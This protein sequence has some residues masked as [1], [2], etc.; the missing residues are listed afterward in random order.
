MFGRIKFF[1]SQLI[2]INVVN[3]FLHNTRVLNFK[4]FTNN[5]IDFSSRFVVQHDFSEYLLNHQDQKKIEYSE[6]LLT[7][8]KS[9][10][11][12]DEMIQ[13]LDVIAKHC[14][15]EGDCISNE[16]YTKFVQDLVERIPKLTQEEIVRFLITLKK[17]PQTKHAHETNYQ[18][19]WET[20]D[21]VCRNNVTVWKSPY[22]L[23]LCALWN[24]LYLARN[25]NFVFASLR[26]VARQI[27]KYSAGELVEFMFYVSICRK[28][29]EMLQVEKRMLEVFDD[30]TIH[31]I[32]VLCGAF[33]KSQKKIKSF[34]LISR[35][36]DKLIK[37]IDLVSEITL[38]GI[39]KNL[40]YCSDVTHS[41]KLDELNYLLA[42][43]VQKHSLMCSVH[44]ALLGTNLQCYNQTLM[45][46]IVERFNNSIKEA[47]AKDLERIVMAISLYNFKARDGS[48]KILLNKIIEEIK[49]RAKE[50]GKHPKSLTSLVHF[51]T[52]CGVYDLDILKSIMTEKFILF[53]YGKLLLI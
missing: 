18:D 27:G 25:S 46:N 41:D 44:M 48:E 8:N 12:N 43:Q 45:E 6:S 47:R 24:N 37:D 33:F 15:S 10:Y 28:D 39:L 42:N 40:R 2:R 17:L 5:E 26:K 20:L 29:V 16:K 14:Q 11:S 51:L 50:F 38:A 13:I 30:F 34:E 22:L 3:K 49:L 9:N 36:F 23:K 19:L 7:S 53:T 1:R 32:G 52:I 21:E 4:R 35:I 31:E